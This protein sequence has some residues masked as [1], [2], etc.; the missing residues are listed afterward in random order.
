MKNITGGERI[1]WGSDDENCSQDALSCVV[2]PM[3]GL[4]RSPY[5]NLRNIRFGCQFGGGADTG[6]GYLS[7][8]NLSMQG[9]VEI[10]IFIKLP[11]SI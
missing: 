6:E 7:N 4:G 3:S 9:W 2:R 1:L 5:L 8:I 11:E 10:H